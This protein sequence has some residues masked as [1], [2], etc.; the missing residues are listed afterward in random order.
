[1]HEVPKQ[2][3]FFDWDQLRIN[4]KIKQNWNRDSF[5]LP[6]HPSIFLGLVGVLTSPSITRLYHGRAP[7]QSV[8]QFLRAVTHETETGDHD[9]CLSRSHYTA[10]TPTQPVGSGRPE[11]ES[12][13]GPPHQESCALPTELWRPLSAMDNIKLFH[14]VLFILLS[15]MLPMIY[16][17]GL[18]E[19]WDKWKHC[20]KQDKK[21]GL[22]EAWDKWKHCYKQD[23][24]IGLR[25]P[26]D[27]WKHCYKQDKK[28][29]LREP[30]DK[31]KHCYKQD[32]KI[33]LRKA[34]DK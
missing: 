12:S 1:M 26:W 8:W 19:P 28:I 16:Y 9:F 21:I 20:H 3:V 24:K 7:R 18:R 5:F 27:K 34:W 29:G 10:L 14:S 32:K 31:W 25:E 4:L 11:R 2:L 17:I 6:F 22:R 15:S 13:P 23:K 33:G 30:W